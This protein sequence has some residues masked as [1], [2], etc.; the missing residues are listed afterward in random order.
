M[1]ILTRDNFFKFY[2]NIKSLTLIEL[3]ISSIIVSIIILS[4]YSID[5]Y[6]RNQVINS[7]R[8]TRVQNELSYVLAHMSKY[9]QQA[10][11]NFNDPAILPTASG[12]QVRVD[13]NDP[14][15]T[16]AQTPSDFDDDSWV[17]YQ[18]NSNTIAAS[19][20]TVSGICP[21]DFV[22]GDLTNRIVAGFVN[23][24]ILSDP[25]PPC[26][27]DGKGFFVAIEDEGSSVNIGLIGRFLPNGNLSITNPEVALKAK[28][29]CHSCSSN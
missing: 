13:L 21:A 9:V 7:E 16:H 2:N 26:A 8:R 23:D 17:S 6:S 24:C 3:I 10:N 5:S 14:T 18:L 27:G 25:L 15:I 1:S 19:C 12:F 4:I 11:G 22:S 28:V 20:T 29:I